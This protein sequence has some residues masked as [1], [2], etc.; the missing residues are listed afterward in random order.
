[1]EIPPSHVTC[2]N[3]RGPPRPTAHVVQGGHACL[4][5]ESCKLPFHGRSETNSPT[6]TEATPAEGTT[7]CTGSLRARPC[8]GPSSSRACTCRRVNPTEPEACTEEGKERGKVLCLYRFV[9]LGYRFFV[10][11]VAVAAAVVDIS[12]IGSRVSY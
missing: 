1:M 8:P 2:D 9:L 4:S 12:I 5:N 10:S 11:L 7:G 3:A 6:C